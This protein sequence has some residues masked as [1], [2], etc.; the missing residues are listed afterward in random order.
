[1]FNSEMSVRLFITGNLQSISDI[2]ITATMKRI[3]LVWDILCF[4]QDMT[5]VVLRKLHLQR[6]R[7]PN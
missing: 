2:F 4:M 7:L 5:V 1:M 6:R 3:D